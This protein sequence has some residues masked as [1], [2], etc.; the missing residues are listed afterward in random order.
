MGPQ[1]STSE[2][3]RSSRAYAV[4]NVDPELLEDRWATW[5][6]LGEYGPNEVLEHPGEWWCLVPSQ[7]LIEYNTL[8]MNILQCDSEYVGYWVRLVHEGPL[9]YIECLRLLHHLLKDKDLASSTS[10]GPKSS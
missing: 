9:G 5:K 3:L 1:P 6:I 2:Y 10:E 7:D 8:L 4:E